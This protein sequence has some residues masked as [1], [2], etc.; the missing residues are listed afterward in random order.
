MRTEKLTSETSLITYDI[1]VL[2]II[3]PTR[4]STDQREHRSFSIWE[5]TWSHGETN[6]F[7]TSRCY[8]FR[9]RFYL[10]C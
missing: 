10:E 5:A 3:W 1:C 9:F 8:I 2:C 6:G 4:S 7:R